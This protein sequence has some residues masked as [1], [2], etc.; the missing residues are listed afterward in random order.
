[1]RSNPFQAPQICSQLKPKPKDKKEASNSF[2]IKQMIQVWFI[3]ANQR[4]KE[5]IKMQG[6]TKGKN[7]INTQGS[8]VF[9]CVLFG[10]CLLLPLSLPIASAD[11]P[12][13]KECLAYAFTTSSNHKFLLE[14][15]ISAFGNNMTIIHN[16]EY[17]EVYTNNTFSA[18]TENEELNFPLE[19]GSNN[20]LLVSGNYS[21]RIDNVFIYPD[22]LSWEFEWQEWQTGDE[23]EI[24][25]FMSLAEAEA[26]ENWA[27]ILSIVMVFSLVTMVYWNLINS[28]VDRNYCEEV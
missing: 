20:I 22:R 9:V 23:Y 7:K 11:P 24:K 6:K 10:V 4:K 14:S 19:M 16:C 27:S 3:L 18:Y 2:I 28:Y 13:Q 15:N 8:A 17:I 5:G 12:E 21:K 1:M 26:K 25:D